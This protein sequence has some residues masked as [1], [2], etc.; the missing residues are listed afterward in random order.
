MSDLY[1]TAQIIQSLMKELR[2]THDQ[3]RQQQIARQ[4]HRLTD[5][6]SENEQHEVRSLLD[7]T[8]AA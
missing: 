3:D 5:R 7:Q 1:L 6:L 2:A 4:L 8:N